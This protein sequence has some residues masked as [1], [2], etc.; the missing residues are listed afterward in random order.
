MLSQKLLFN[1]DILKVYFLFG[2]RL[3]DVLVS[4]LL[5]VALFPF[6]AFISLVI[7]CFSRGPIFFKQERV[8]KDLAIFFVYK[9]R[10]MTVAHREVGTTP[11]IGKAEGGS[12]PTATIMLSNLKNNMQVLFDKLVSTDSKFA[13]VRLGHGV[14]MDDHWFEYGMIPK[15]QGI[16]KSIALVTFLN[17]LQQHFLEH[18][19]KVISQDEGPQGYEFIV[20][21]NA[22]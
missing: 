16:T 6:F 19:M 12:S 2:K 10:T 21:V 22:L 17:T 8:G 7:V 5:L 20:E 4:K 18:F 14:Q 15:T 11:I 9:F 3:I 13:T 1:F